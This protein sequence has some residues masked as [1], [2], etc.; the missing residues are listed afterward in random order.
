MSNA[1]STGLE[2]PE[3]EPKRLEFFGRFLFNLIM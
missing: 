1:A 3:A 2:P